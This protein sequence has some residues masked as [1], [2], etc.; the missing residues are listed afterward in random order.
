MNLGLVEIDADSQIR[1]AN[2]RYTEMIGLSQDYLL[3]KNVLDVMDLDDENLA[4]IQQQ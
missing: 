2:N 3:G 4:I 1:M